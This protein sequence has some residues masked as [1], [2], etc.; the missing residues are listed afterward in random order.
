VP[1]GSINGP[2]IQPRPTASLP[3]W[4][5]VGQS[6]ENS[7]QD[8]GPPWALGRMPEPRRPPRQP[9]IPTHL[10]AVQERCGDEVWQALTCELALLNQ[11]SG[12]E[13]SRKAVAHVSRRN[14]E[15]ASDLQRLHE[16]GLV[17]AGL[18]QPLRALTP[19]LQGS[20]PLCW[21]IL[22]NPPSSQEKAKFDTAGLD[23]TSI[24]AL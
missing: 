6:L 8:P 3:V 16:A 17:P 19:R 13:C 20:T 2:L 1:C 4:V 18:A 9:G 21:S 22:Q 11:P 24:Q 12:R 10:T 23:L 5:R 15:L 14:P 7:H